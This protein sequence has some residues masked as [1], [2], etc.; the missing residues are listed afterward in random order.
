MYL[1]A[2]LF[3]HQMQLPLWPSIPSFLTLTTRYQ[4]FQPGPLPTFSLC[5]LLPAEWDPLKTW[6]KLYNSSF[7]FSQLTQNK[8]AY[9]C[10]KIPCVPS[11]HPLQLPLWLYILYSLTCS[12]C[13]LRFWFPENSSYSSPTGLGTCCFFYLI[14]LSPSC[15]L[16]KLTCLILTFQWTLSSH[17]IKKFTW[18]LQFSFGV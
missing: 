1:S 6:I 7:S 3:H 9:V 12:L 16:S 5:S 10:S 2:D 11:L 18:Y 14:C 8:N 13:T 15:L 4:V 17:H